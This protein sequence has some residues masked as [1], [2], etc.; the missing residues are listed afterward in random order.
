[1]PLAT[2]AGH[3]RNGGPDDVGDEKRISFSNEDLQHLSLFTTSSFKFGNRRLAR[4]SNR[5]QPMKTHNAGKDFTAKF[6]QNS[7]DTSTY[8]ILFVIMSK[9][10][11]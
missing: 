8:E 10:A 7:T 5:R 4:R 9:F 1:M 11:H 6:M 2:L 3:C